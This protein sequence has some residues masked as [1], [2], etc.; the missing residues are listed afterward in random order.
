M[1]LMLYFHRTDVYR[2]VIH[3]PFHKFTSKD[4]AVFVKRIVILVAQSVTPLD[5][6]D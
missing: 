3:Q 1:I 5:G 2:Y 4:R 6:C